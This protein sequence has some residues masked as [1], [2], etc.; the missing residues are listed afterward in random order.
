MMED[1]EMYFRGGGA[2]INSG[3]GGSRNFSEKFFF[4]G[5]GANFLTLTFGE[6]YCTTIVLPGVYNMLRGGA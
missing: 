6:M 2:V 1:W 3:G 5:G 4:F